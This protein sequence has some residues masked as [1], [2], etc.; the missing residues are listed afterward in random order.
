M[1]IKIFFLL[2]TLIPTSV[3]GQ[4]E[5][6]YDSTKHRIISQDCDDRIFTKVEVLPSLKKGIK[7]FEDTLTSCLKSI[8]AFKNGTHVTFKFLV[9]TSS[10]IYDIEREEGQTQN[11]T[12]IKEILLACSFMWKTAIQNGRQVCALVRLEVEI[13]NDKLTAIIKQ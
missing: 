5:V 4:S 7:N 9:T 6:K 10:H 2:V 1:I 11:E 8:N 13:S 12:I 3:F